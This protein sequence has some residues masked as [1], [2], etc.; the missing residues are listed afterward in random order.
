M[1]NSIIDTIKRPTLLVNMER[2]KRNITLMESKATVSGVLFRPHFKTHQS[3]EIGEIFRERG[4][5]AITVSNVEMANYFANNGWE[6]ITLAFSVNLREIEEID[7]LA[8][9]IKLGILV[10]SAEAVNFLE[11]NL[12][13]RV[14][15][16]IKIDVGSRRTGIDSSDFQGAL[17]LVQIISKSKKLSLAGLLTHAGHTYHATSIEKIKAIYRDTIDKLYELKL[18]LRRK[19]YEGILLS[20]GDTPACSVV[21]DFSE[22]D[23]IRPG[24]FVFYDVTQYLLGSC[25][26]EHIA[27]ALAAPVVAKHPTRGEIV[28]HGGAI[29][30]SKDSVKLEDGTPIYGLVSLPKDSKDNPWGKSLKDSYVKSLS[31]EHGVVKIRKDYFDKINIGDIIFI[32]PVHSC[33]TANLMRSYLSTEGRV[34]ETMNTIHYDSKYYR[35]G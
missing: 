21:S 34:I 16:W 19:G 3:A 13:N 4:T 5:R 24:N 22:V 12:T 26:E 25:K 20:I 31:Q 10:E 7:T 11:E 8:G 15:T 27:V 1:G 6:D 14:Q 23:E 32:L 2:V 9:R 17:N 18:F 28:V 35:R 33:L 29:H 30:L